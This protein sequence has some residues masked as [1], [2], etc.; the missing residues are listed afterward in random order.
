[1]TGAPN[2]LGP[3]GRA[4]LSHWTTSDKGI[5]PVH[6]VTPFFSQ[7]PF[8]CDPNRLTFIE[9]HELQI[10]LLQATIFLCLL[11]LRDVNII[12]SAMFS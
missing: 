7:D 11:L 10:S 2:L 9:E 5:C 8:A 3:L 12:L 6:I 4:N 1:M